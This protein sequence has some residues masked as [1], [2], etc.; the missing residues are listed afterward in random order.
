M[1]Q[2]KALESL[3]DSREIK[4]V[5]REI[6]PEYS[7]ERLML[8]L[9]YFAT[10]CNQLMLGKTEGRRR[11]GQQ[12]TSWLDG[13]INSVD[14]GLGRLREVGEDRQ[15]WCP[16]AMGLQRIRHNRATEQESHR[17]R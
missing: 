15:D 14:M 17:C 13:F 8:K 9:Q 7:L 4:P 2:E 10:G 6:N 11:R 1:A 16:A 3:L 12:R 5:L